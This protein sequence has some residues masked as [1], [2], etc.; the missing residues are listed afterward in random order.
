VNADCNAAHHCL[1]ASDRSTE[2][3]RRV[4][5]LEEIRANAVLSYDHESVALIDKMIKDVIEEW[6]ESFVNEYGEERLKKTG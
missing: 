1:R 2:L 5:R 4:E 6:R 3:R